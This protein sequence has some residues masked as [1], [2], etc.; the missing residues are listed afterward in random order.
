M[1]RYLNSKQAKE[2]NAK[3][4]EKYNIKNKVKCHGVK[5]VLICSLLSS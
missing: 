4:W 2:L 1:I 5:K 3:K